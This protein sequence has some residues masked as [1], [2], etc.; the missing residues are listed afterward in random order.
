MRVHS[1]APTHARLPVRD[2]DLGFRTARLLFVLGLEAA[3]A[4]ALIG[5]ITSAS[6]PS[7]D[8]QAA[9]PPLNADDVA[10]KPTAFRSREITVAGRIRPR[11]TRVSAQDR[12]AFVLEGARDGRLLVVPADDAKLPAYRPGTAV[13]VRG[14]VVIPPD[15]RRLARRVASRTAVAERAGAAAILKAAEVLVVR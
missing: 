14:T 10:G 8:A 9:A 12:R 2:H 7:A 3:V 1:S 6:T 15:S 4:F 11:P 13:S 5:T